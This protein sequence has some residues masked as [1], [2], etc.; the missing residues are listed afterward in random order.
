MENLLLR[1]MFSTS[2][3]R[4]LRI[5]HTQKYRSRISNY[6]S[7][8][9]PTRVSHRDAGWL[10]LSTP[11]LKRA[12]ARGLS[13][14]TVSSTLSTILKVQ[15]AHSDQLYEAMDALG[16]RQQEIQQSLVG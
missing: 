15:D 11:L 12:R 16:E 7:S 4:R 3:S 14:H 6:R 1:S 9:S 2:P 10:E 5:T 13:T 8:K